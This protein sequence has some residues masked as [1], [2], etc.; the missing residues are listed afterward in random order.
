MTVSLKMLTDSVYFKTIAKFRIDSGYF[1]ETV[2]PKVL[3]F[4]A[5]LLNFMHDTVIILMY[6]KILHVSTT[7][8]NFMILRDISGNGN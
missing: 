3:N 8:S 2:N 4:I 5:I 1:K 7:C 6:K